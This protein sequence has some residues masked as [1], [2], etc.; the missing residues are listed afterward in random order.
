CEYDSLAADQQFSDQNPLNR[1]PRISWGFTQFQI[2]AE[3]DANGKVYV[4]S[5][6]ERFDPPPMLDDTRLV[7]TIERNEPGYDPIIALAY[8]D[9]VNSDPFMGFDP[10]EAKMANMGATMEF[11]STVGFYWKVNYEIHFHDNSLATVDDG[12]DQYV[13]DKGSYEL[14]ANNK[15]KRT[16][17]QSTGLPIASGVLLNGSAKKILT[18]QTGT[19]SASTATV[20]S[21]TDTSSL[22]PG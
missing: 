7:C 21:L 17:D 9:A 11:E 15:P 4:N 18:P 6:G 14:D 20:T 19:T 13:L 8:K 3:Q 2:A 1:P 22:A 10:G 16:L 5:A 12:W